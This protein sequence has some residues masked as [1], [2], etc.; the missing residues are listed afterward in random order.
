M[1]R[2]KTW[3]DFSCYV[4]FPFC[5][6]I[7]TFC[8]YETRLISRSQVD[9]F[10]D[11][12]MRELAMYKEADS[13]SGS[14]VRS[15]FL[16]GGTASLMPP[17]LLESVV[18]GVRA[19]SI[20]HEIPEFTLEC[21]PGTISGTTLARARAAG[22]NR[23]NVCAQSFSDD[24]L[25]RVTRQHSVRDTRDLIESVQSVGITNM[26]VDLMYGLPGQSL[27]DWE[28]NLRLAVALPFTHISAYKLY[29]FKHGAIDRLNQAPR[30]ETET[31]T[32]TR[33]FRAMYQM[34]QTI[35]QEAGF[36]QYT[37]TEW[38]LPGYSS[39][40]LCD[41]F[42]G[43]DLLPIGPSAFGGCG[44]DVWHNSSYVGKYGDADNWAGLRRGCHM[45]DAEAFKRHVIL[46]LWLLE[47][48]L[49]QAAERRAISPS[50]ILVDTLKDLEAEGLLGFDGSKISLSRDQRFDAGKAMATL[51]SVESSDWTSSPHAY[52]NAEGPTAA[53]LSSSFMSLLRMLRND[54][55]FFSLMSANPHAALEQTGSIAKREANALLDAIAGKGC[56]D[57]DLSA[58]WNDIEQEH[59]ARLRSRRLRDKSGRKSELGRS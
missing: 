8:N 13:F 26:H 4:H 3:S 2:G 57:L 45:S 10:A 53:P 51:A 43:E 19:L 49:L 37:L 16:G 20:N 58:V 22:V 23:V 41:T 59:A 12:V 40:F 44:D 27:A 17:A 36:E 54:P 11:S 15:L 7:C 42:G 55:E 21:E 47:V 24:E 56:T 18:E 1:R 14:T 52:L 28:H 38:A 25:R 5:R 33:A 46:G 50:R 9:A 32:Q 35:L 31:D 30:A 39:T 29:V 34:A 6:H 48:D